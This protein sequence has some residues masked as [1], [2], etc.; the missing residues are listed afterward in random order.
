LVIFFFWNNATRKL[1][2]EQPSQEKPKVANP[3]EKA[4]CEANE[5]V[6]TAKTPTKAYTF[7]RVNQVLDNDTTYPAEL[8]LKSVVSTSDRP[9]K[10]AYEE[11]ISVQV[12]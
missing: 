3:V 12:Q 7:K 9:L 1:K 11:K 2:Q 8:A 4:F 10:P 6:S 5:L